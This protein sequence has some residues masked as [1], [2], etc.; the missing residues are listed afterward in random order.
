[1][2]DFGV[3]SPQWDVA[4]TLFKAQG[5]M[6]KEVVVGGLEELAVVDSLKEAAFSRHSRA[7]AHMTS[8]RGGQQSHDLPRLTDTVPAW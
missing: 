7:D 1:M 3:L 5:F 2:R 6:H 4:G 8:Q